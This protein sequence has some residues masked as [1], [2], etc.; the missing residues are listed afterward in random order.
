M[1]ANYTM[2]EEWLPD[3]DGG[4]W[5]VRTSSSYLSSDWCY[6]FSAFYLSYLS[7]LRPSNFALFG[8]GWLI[9]KYLSRD[10]IYNV[11]MEEEKR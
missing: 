5:L 4:A 8:C 6:H 11:G 7:R 10:R 3:V 9:I 1:E 2:N